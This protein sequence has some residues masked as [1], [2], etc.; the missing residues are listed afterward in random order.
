MIV[1]DFNATF[2]LEATPTIINTPVNAELIR[3]A[4]IPLKNAIVTQW[5]SSKSMITVSKFLFL[6]FVVI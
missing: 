4:S 1:M 6:L 5:P 3:T 2:G